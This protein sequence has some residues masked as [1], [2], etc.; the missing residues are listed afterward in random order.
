MS[1]RWVVGD[2]DGVWRVK[3]VVRV[4]QQAYAKKKERKESRTHCVF[5]YQV[6][7]KHKCDRT[8]ES[9]HRGS[10]VNCD[11]RRPL[12]TES[13]QSPAKRWNHNYV[14]ITLSLFLKVW[15][16]ELL[17]FIH[18]KRFYKPY[19]L[20]IQWTPTTSKSSEGEETTSRR[21]RGHHHIM[22]KMIKTSQFHNMCILF[23]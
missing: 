3:C 1:R 20:R 2:S 17:I 7:V 11:W 13:S 18:F 15:R 8:A 21:H 19:F 9:G 10:T 23:L 4:L 22:K 16:E 5:S 6:S 14:I 12:S